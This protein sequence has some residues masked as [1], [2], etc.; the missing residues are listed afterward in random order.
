[1]RREFIRELGGDR[2]KIARPIDS[3]ELKRLVARGSRRLEH[4]LLCLP[5]ADVDVI[6]GVSVRCRMILESMRLKWR[7]KASSPGGLLFFWL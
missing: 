3:E 7:D 4:G 1:M 5:F 2:R 6:T